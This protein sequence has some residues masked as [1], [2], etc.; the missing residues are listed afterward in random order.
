MLDAGARAA[1]DYLVVR[2]A[3]FHRGYVSDWNEPTRT[4]NCDQ[5]RVKGSEGSAVTA[6]IFDLN[7]LARAFKTRRQSKRSE[8]G[9]GKRTFLS[10][11]SGALANNTTADS[12]T[13]VWAF[14]LFNNTSLF[15][16]RNTV[17]SWKALFK[18]YNRRREHDNR[19]FRIRGD[20]PLFHNTTGTFNTAV[21]SGAL[22]DNLEGNENVAVGSMRLCATPAARTWH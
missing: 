14:A 21:G 22:N 13:G 10:V 8:F 12:N 18:Q 7:S 16:G 3:L 19:D 6:R 15:D 20:P 5:C 9:V 11:F 1:P 17:V 2:S 4:A